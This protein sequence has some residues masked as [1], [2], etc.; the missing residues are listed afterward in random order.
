M[1]TPKSRRPCPQ[2]LVQIP[3]NS[4]LTLPHLQAGHR[5]LSDAS[6]SQE[7]LWGLRREED[8]AGGL[9]AVELKLLCFLVPVDSSFVP[10]LC[11]DGQTAPCSCPVCCPGTDSGLGLIPQ[12]APWALVG[13]GLLLTAWH[14]HLKC[15]EGA[16]RGE[17]G[18]QRAHSGQAETLG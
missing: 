11:L 4:D 10:I 15:Q 14:L 7:I 5:V 8:L 2:C 6:V 17:T 3:P 9:R 13:M 18:E 1:L 12:G 16:A